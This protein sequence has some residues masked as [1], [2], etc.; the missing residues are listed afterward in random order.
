MVLNKNMMETDFFDIV[1]G[2]LEGVTLAP[3][4]FIIYLDYLLWTSIDL[5]KEK[6]KKQTSVHVF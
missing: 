1:A 2:V 4:L 3:Y 5:M 6:G